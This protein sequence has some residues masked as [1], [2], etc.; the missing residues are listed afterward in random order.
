M[1]KYIFLLIVSMLLSLGACDYLDV[2]PDNVATL[3]NAFTDKYNAEKFLFTC[4][5]YLPKMGDPSQNPALLGS[6]EMSL[7]KYHE[8]YNGVQ[9]ANGYQTMVN[10]LFD[11]WRGYNGGSPLYIGIRDCNIFL[12][13]INGVPDISDYE[14]NIWIAE[15]KFIKAYLHFYLLR[16]YG[17]IHIVRENLSIT[18]SLDNLKLSRDPVDD[19]FDY[20]VSLLDEAIDG[21]PDDIQSDITHL[22]H[23]TK[24]IAMGVKAKVLVTR[25]SPLFNGQW[26]LQLINKDGTKLFPQQEETIIAQKW[27]DAAKACEEAILQADKIG[28]RLLEINDF[29]ESGA[30]VSDTTKLKT[31]LRYRVTKRDNDEV[32]WT[33]TNSAVSTGGLQSWSIP[34]SILAFAI[35][36]PCSRPK[37]VAEPATPTNKAA[38]IPFLILKSLFVPSLSFICLLFRKPA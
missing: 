5:S 7:G 36:I 24:T 4:Y 32:I 1:R 22:G 16:M 21:L 34:A 38:A 30:T 3:D 17:P 18:E 31:I 10:P 19:C 9:L 27:I 20:V 14:K 35:G 23:I 2:V 13:R 28:H 37:A 26:G 25:A 11:Y 6:D 8:S 15:V 29:D 12:E 33:H